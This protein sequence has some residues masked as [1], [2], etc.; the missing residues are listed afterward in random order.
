MSDEKIRGIITPMLTPFDSSEELDEKRVLRLIDHLLDGGVYGLFPSAS[1]GEF[2][3]MTVDERKRLI[4]VVMDKV[5]G[6][7]PVM[8]GTGSSSLRDTLE[9]TTFAEKLDC[10]AAIVITPYY[11]KPG[12]EGLKK[13]YERIAVKV[14]LDL[15]LYQL[16]RATGVRFEPET[17][18]DLA[19]EHDNIVGIKDSSGDLAGL[20]KIH[21]ETGDDFVILQGKDDLLL[22]SLT[23]GM[24]GGVPGTS[25][26]V[27]EL[28]VEVYESFIEGEVERAMSLQREKL[29]VLSDFCTEQGEFPA[30]YKAL[31]RRVGLDLGVP[32]TPI[33][34]VD[35]E[36][37]EGISLSEFY[38]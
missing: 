12:Q 35:Q 37:L 2:S 8:P 38:P 14:D 34:E 18:A 32:R 30:G 1:I 24:D 33:T 26:I 20:L 23:A 17:V 28:A 16:P 31:A 7:V 22:S 21:R 9:L 36:L 27:P 3:S 10:R 11:L 5:E 29:S 13:Y 6:E 19:S 15:I 4:E 25:N